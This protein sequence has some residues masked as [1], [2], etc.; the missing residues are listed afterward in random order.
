[1][2][3]SGADAAGVIQAAKP[4]DPLA[5]LAD[6]DFLQLSS[7]QVAALDRRI[8]RLEVTPDCASPIRAITRSSRYRALSVPAAP[9]AV[10]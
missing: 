5:F 2:P 3:D 1:M 9:A 10:S 4:D 7:S 8:R 6:V